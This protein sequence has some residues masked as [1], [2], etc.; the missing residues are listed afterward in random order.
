MPTTHQ[1]PPGG[2]DVMPCC[3]RTPFE[4]P[5]TDRVTCSG[6]VT[7]RTEPAGMDVELV[8]GDGPDLA[9]HLEQAGIHL[10]A[11]QRIVEALP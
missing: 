9:H 6:L 10:R 3:G 4:A 8:E 11:A 1:C 2:S 7:C 5:P